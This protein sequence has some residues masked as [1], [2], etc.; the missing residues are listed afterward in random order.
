MRLL[1]L[2]LLAACTGPADPPADPVLPP[3]SAW[4]RLE[5][6]WS[7][8]THN[9]YWVD[10]GAP[11]DLFASGTNERILDQVLGDGA[12]SVELDVHRDPDVPGGFRVYHTVPGNSQCDSLADCLAP[13]ALFHDTVPE[14]MPVTI[15][16]ELKELISSNFDATHT[17]DDL[18]A[19]FRAAFGDRL[20]TPGDLLDRCDALGARTDTLS[21]CV[22]DVRWPDVHA[23]RGRFLVAILGNWDTLGAVSTADWADYATTDL[24]HR[25][26]FPMASTWRLD[27]TTLPPDVAQHVTPETLAAAVD[28]SVFVQVET[29]DDPLLLPSLARGAIVRIDGHFSPEQQAA[30]TAL[31]VQLLQTDTPWV[32]ADPVAVDQPLRSLRD[33]PDP[34]VMVEPSARLTLDDAQPEHVLFDGDLPDFTWVTLASGHDGQRGACLRVDGGDGT[35]SL[36]VCRG[37]VEDPGQ[38]D[39]LTA[40]V[41]LVLCDE[42]GACT[43]IAQEVPDNTVADR[44]GV[45]RSSTPGC[46]D[47]QVLSSVRVDGTSTGFTLAGPLCGSAP[48]NRGVLVRREGV[49]G[50]V[51]AFATVEGGG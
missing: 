50:P 47:L 19:I 4:P 6:T 18:D 43:T 15:A 40:R 22:E 3:E 33:E 31:G 9:A 45:A 13:L 29:E 49:T 23:L 5:Q 48:Y 41:E 7:M 39:H 25:A 51:G 44:L 46:V 12:R 2:L 38:P 26:A 1:P 36:T 28:A 30:A 16:L 8:A 42:L 37:R 20:Y 10:R 27:H 14:H 34:T 32:Q 21:H 35:A 24:V 11:S 17:V